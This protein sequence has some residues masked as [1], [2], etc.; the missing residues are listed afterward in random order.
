MCLVVSILNQHPHYLF[1]FLRLLQVAVPF[2]FFFV[3]CQK[4]W[5]WGWSKNTESKSLKR[6]KLSGKK[7]YLHGVSI[8]ELYRVM[9]DWIILTWQI[10]YTGPVSSF[11]WLAT[12]CIPMITTLIW[13]PSHSQSTK[14]WTISLAEVNG[15][16]LIWILMGHDNHMTPLSFTHSCNAHI[17]AYSSLASCVE[18]V[19][20]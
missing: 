2:S 20:T 7:K 1:L 12:A 14:R 9:H 18:H 3:M 4:R 16:S 11:A 10:H 5:A 8:F 17:S 13:G 19:I 6:K 15:I